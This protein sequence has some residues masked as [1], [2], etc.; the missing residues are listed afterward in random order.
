MIFFLD[1][2]GVMVHA[3]PHR[4]VEQAADGFYVFSSA[5]VETFNN[6]FVAEEDQVIL[7][8]SHRFRYIIV[9]W[10]KIFLDRDILIGSLALLDDVQQHL[11]Y[12]FTR[13]D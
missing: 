13:K 12:R 4:H 6:I 11:N 10:K 3:N 9:E 2:D 8:S 5:A 1:I 7:S